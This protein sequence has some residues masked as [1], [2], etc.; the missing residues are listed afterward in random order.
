[1]H[2]LL[3]NTVARKRERTVWARTLK[4]KTAIGKC[5]C[6]CLCVRAIIRSPFA[7]KRT[8]A[9]RASGR[10]CHCQASRV[11]EA[12]LNF[13][14]CSGADIGIGT[15]KDMDIVVVAPGTVS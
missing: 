5:V 13:D 8:A 14:Y 3:G 4:L 15:D 12:E 7:G 1:M 2:I 11:D 10:H 6:L 9:R